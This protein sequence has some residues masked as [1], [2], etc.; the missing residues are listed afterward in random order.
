[1]IFG[2]VN[3]WIKIYTCKFFSVAFF[4]WQVFKWVSVLLEDE[5]LCF[6]SAGGIQWLLNNKLV[7][8][9]SD[10]W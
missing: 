5:C 7:V 10:V 4:F 1:M 3:T 2:F 8:L 6:G 9:E